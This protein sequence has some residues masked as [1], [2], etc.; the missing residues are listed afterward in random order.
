MVK[1]STALGAAICAGVGVG[2]FQDVREAAHRVVNW[3]QTFEPNEANHRKYR[4][5]YDEWSK[6]YRHELKMAGDGLVQPMFRAAGT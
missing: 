4:K 5:L 1:E 2:I 3:E 6:V